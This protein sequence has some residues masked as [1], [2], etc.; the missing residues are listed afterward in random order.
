MTRTCCVLRS[1]NTGAPLISVHTF[2]SITHGIVVLRLRQ[3]RHIAHRLAGD[4]NY[5][6]AYR[7]V[8]RLREVAN[9]C[10]RMSNGTEPED[11]PRL[12]VLVDAAYSHLYDLRAH[13]REV[14]N[15]ARDP[16]W[17]WVAPPGV[18]VP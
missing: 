2:D 5:V 8:S 7:T 12:Q 16:A 13:L 10:D 14:L 18:P 3:L 17:V 6:H 11:M 9:C 4:C 15:G 1:R